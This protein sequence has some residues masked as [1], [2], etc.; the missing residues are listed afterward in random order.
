M[1]ICYTFEAPSVP[2]WWKM[3]SPPH[4]NPSLGRPFC[5]SS[6]ALRS[7]CVFRFQVSV[8]NVKGL[9]F[10]FRFQRLDSGLWCRSMV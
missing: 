5:L 10:N 3:P 4:P 2:R 7:C 8:S 6:A 9:G 1:Y